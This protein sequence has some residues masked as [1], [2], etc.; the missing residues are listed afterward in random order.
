MTVTVN[1]LQHVYEQLSVRTHMYT[2]YEQV[3]NVLAAFRQTKV[4]VADQRNGLCDGLV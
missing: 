4:Y 3:D 1:E 2:M